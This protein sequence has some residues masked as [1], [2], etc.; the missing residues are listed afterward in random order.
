MKEE[1]YKVKEG[2]NIS[3]LLPVRDGQ[4]E[5]CLENLNVTIKFYASLREKLGI[6]KVALQ[7]KENSKFMAVM[8]KMME[9]VGNKAYVICDKLEIKDNVMVSINNNLIKRSDLAELR[10]KEGDVIDIMPLPSGG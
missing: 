3:I 1:K 9:I 5:D 6:N 2:D 7:L 4:G 10:L 8:E